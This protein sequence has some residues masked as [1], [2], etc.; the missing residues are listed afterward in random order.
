LQSAGF[1]TFVSFIAIDVSIIFVVGVGGIFVF[2][3][4]PIHPLPKE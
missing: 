3:S 4:Y 1:F 2:V